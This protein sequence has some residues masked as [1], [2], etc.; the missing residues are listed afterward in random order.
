[1]SRKKP[2]PRSVVPVERTTQTLLADLRTLIDGTRG[3]VAQV[4]NAGLTLM[5]WA[6]GD[7]IRREIL[8][9]KRAEYGKQILRTLSEKLTADYG[10]GFGATNLSLMVRFAEAFPDQ[11][12]VATLSRQLGW[13]HFREIIGSNGIGDEFRDRRA[14][15]SIASPSRTSSSR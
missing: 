12:I 11:P 9:E 1:M 13:S 14:F 15:P 8:G 2:T 5:Y 10:R 6:V 3:Q 7:R 4:V